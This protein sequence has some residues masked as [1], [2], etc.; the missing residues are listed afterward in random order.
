MKPIFK[1]AVAMVTISLLAACASA[2][3]ER[4]MNFAASA[5]TKLSAAVDATVRFNKSSENLADAEL[6]RLSASDDPSLLTPF[7]HYSL[8]V[9]RS[10]RRS[11]VLVCEPDGGKALLE[12]AGCTPKLDRHHWQ[13]VPVAACD[14]TLD[15]IA[16]CGP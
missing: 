12:D 11:V 2:Q 1:G 7:E 8:R 3:S 4:D 9:L 15:V 5:L 10:G 14:F 13:S 6:L 16:A